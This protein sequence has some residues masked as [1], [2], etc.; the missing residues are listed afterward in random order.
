M[1]PLLSTPP[2]P[3][4]V[5]AEPRDDVSVHAS[6]PCSHSAAPASAAHAEADDGAATTA[7]HSD[8][9]TPVATVASSVAVHVQAPALAVRAL[10][11]LQFKAQKL[12]EGRLDAAAA[13]PAAAAPKAKRKAYRP[14]VNEVQRL[15]AAATAPTSHHA[16]CS[17]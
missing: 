6:D 1:T 5:S 3:L 10:T 4:I 8:P 15:A 12:E 2:V 14:R 17:T 13:A 9:P 7:P 11:K 16:T